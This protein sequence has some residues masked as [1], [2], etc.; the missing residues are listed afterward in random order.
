MSSPRLALFY[1]AIFALIG[2]QTA[3]WP[4]WL[5]GRG[6]GA[7]EI[8]ILFAAAQW[9]KIA[10]NPLAGLLADHSGERRRLMMVLALGC[11]AGYLLC[12]PAHG[13]AALLVL[14]A[15]TSACLSALIPLG[16]SAAL[17][18]TTAGRA[19]YG[20]VRL[21]GTLGFIAATLLGGRVLAGD[22]A[23]GVLYLMLA[24]TAL[25]V[26]ACSLIPRLP[27]SQPVGGAGSP[28][29]HLLERRYLLLLAAATLVQAS[30]SVYYAFGT[31]HWRAIG[32]PT[33]TIAWLWAEGAI[34][35]IAV[36]YYGATLVRRLGPLPLVVLGGAAGVLRWTATALTGALPVLVLVQ[37]LH[38]LTYGAAHLGAMHHLTRTIPPA[39]SATGQAF[40]SAI[41]GGLGGGAVMLAAGALYDAFGA[42]AYFAMAASAGLGALV[43]AWLARSDR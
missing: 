7:A 40:Y 28:W 35:E 19:D 32:V 10:A 3:Y 42:L 27:A 37:L 6:L 30:H 16:D 9:I 31:L 25:L 13:F 39:H 36:F 8:G 17:A 4:V 1:A 21:W 34:A 26:A 41:V 12:L 29:R 33:G 22:D 23:E 18:A 11:F 43:A 5:A 24:A 2:V 20:R 15:A 14:N 38:A